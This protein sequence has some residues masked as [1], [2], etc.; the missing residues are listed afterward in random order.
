MSVQNGNDKKS[1]TRSRF[2]EAARRIFA[3]KGFQATNVSDIVSEVESG[4]GTFYYHFKDKQE[5]FDVLMLD[6]ISRLAIAVTKT[7]T[8]ADGRYP[9]A[10]ANRE[11]AL[12]NA[13]AFAAV[14]IENMDLA[15]IYFRESKFT[16]GAVAEAI[17]RFYSLM[18]YHVEQGL[19]EG[20]QAGVVR[21][22]LDPF[23]AAR[24]FVGAAERLI[25]DTISSRRE[26]KLD[27]LAEQIID[28]QSYGILKGAPEA[29][30]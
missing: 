10:L 2:L 19:E 12:E 9:L 7:S 28:F 22:N 6:F 21:E 27:E 26:I 30:T 23:C 14:F 4:Q 18:Y 5:I 25:Y 13:R 15:E 29:K 17:E 20:M 11:L 8:A 16:G 24:C 3:Q 1:K